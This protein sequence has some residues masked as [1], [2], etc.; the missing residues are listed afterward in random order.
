MILKPNDFHLV[1]SNGNHCEVD[2]TQLRRVKFFMAEVNQPRSKE[3]SGLI[4][5]K[6]QQDISK[7]EI[8][9]S[10]FERE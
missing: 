2:F 7:C 8:T 9:P 3:V 5:R 6:H 4:Y 10:E 1:V